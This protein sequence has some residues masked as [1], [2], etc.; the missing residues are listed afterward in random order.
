MANKFNIMDLMSIR[1]Q[2]EEINTQYTSIMLDPRQV[3]EPPNNTHKDCTDI[4]KLATSFLL[5]GQEQ[6]TILAKI[7]GEFWIVDGTRRNRANIYLIDHGYKQF[8]RVEFRYKEMSKT[9]YELSLLS[10]N[11]FT[12]GLSQYEKTELAARLKIA[13]KEAIEAGEI[14]K[15]ESLRDMIGNILGETSGQMGR[16]EKINN[17]LTPEAKE[18]FKT[19]AIGISAAYETARLPPEDQGKIAEAAAEGKIEAKDIAA[20]VKEK[21]KEEKKLKELTKRAEE[22]AKKAES[23]QIG[24]AQASLSAE[25]A[26]EK[27]DESTSWSEMNPPEMSDLDTE[28]PEEIIKEATFTLQELLLQAEKITYNELLV[29][30]DILMKCNNRHMAAGV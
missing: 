30:Q 26:A 12:Q 27:A 10:G 8:E 5:V 20:M 29:L 19:G 15:P 22:A 23:A 11:G 24:A 14:E 6:P 13:L 2:Q 1:P 21:K 9:I 18:I 3:K 17:S 25:R 7:D 4:D 16:I 28:E